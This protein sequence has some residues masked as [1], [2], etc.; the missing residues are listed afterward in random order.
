VKKFV[1]NLV[2]K[3]AVRIEP[4]KLDLTFIGTR[5]KTRLVVSKI[6]QTT[7]RGRF[8]TGLHMRVFIEAENVMQAR[9]ETKSFV[10]GITSFITLVTGVGLQTPKEELA[11]EITPKVEKREFIQIFNDPLDVQVSRRTLNHKLFNDLL[12]RALKLDSLSHS[13]VARAVQWY[14]MGASTFNIFD[15]F[16]CFW[17]GLESLNLLLQ[18][19]LSVENDP[20]KCSRCGHEWVSLPTI[21]GIRTFIKTSLNDHTKLYQR[22][23]RLRINIMHSRYG[24]DKLLKEAEDLTPKTAEILFRAICFIL[25]LEE[26]KT[27]SH[28]P[29]LAQVPMRIEVEGHLV[30]GEP[31]SLGLNGEDPRLQIKQKPLLQKVSKDWSVSFDAEFDLI[32]R[33]NPSVILQMQ[34]TRF[35]G[36]A[37]THAGM[38]EIERIDSREKLKN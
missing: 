6:E 21:S 27:I 10:D 20:I 11:Y 16:N 8:Q 32:A 22:I 17:I 36:D 7:Q 4:G 1:V 14:R 34:E 37:E 29:I 23:R 15:K 38:A 28:T 25:E 19:K 12:D 35:Y 18:K 24:L 31:N 13:R 26:W 3:P 5:R 9:E 30:G 33:V 2:L